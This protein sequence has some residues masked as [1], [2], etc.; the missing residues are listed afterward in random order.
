MSLSCAGVVNAFK[1]GRTMP[2][3][4]LGYRSADL[5]SGVQDGVGPRSQPVLGGL[6]VVRTELLAAVLGAVVVL[7]GD[8]MS[9]AVLGPGR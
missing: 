2:G 5:V 6:P 7:R 3:G 1:P 9:A 4:E 8:H